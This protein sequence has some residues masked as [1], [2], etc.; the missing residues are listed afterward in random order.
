MSQ[1]CISSM[2]PP[3]HYY[4]GDTSGI[5]KVLERVEYENEK[6]EKYMQELSLLNSEAEVTPTNAICESCAQGRYFS[7]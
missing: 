1:E 3:G 7:V 4:G 5:L 2:D 6:N